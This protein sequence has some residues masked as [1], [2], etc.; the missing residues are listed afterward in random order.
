ML[1]SVYEKG[2]SGVVKKAIVA[3]KRLQLAL[4]HNFE[5]VVLLHQT[6][7]HKDTA[8]RYRR[9]IKTVST[10]ASS[11]KVL[12]DQKDIMEASPTGESEQDDRVAER[13]LRRR[14]GPV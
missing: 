6:V 7:S 10:I 8:R 9:D 5:V 4:Q 14:G 2:G 11:K 13:N 12:K 1:S 3:H